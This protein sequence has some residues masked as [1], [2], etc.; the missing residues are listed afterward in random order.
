MSIIHGKNLVVKRKQGTSYTAIAAAKSCDIIV[1]CDTIET[2][3]AT[4]ADW[5]AFIAGRKE[6]EVTCSFLVSEIELDETLVG[7]TVM[8]RFGTSNDYMTGYAI[9]T[10]WHVTGTY[11]NLAQGSFRFKG[12]DGL[13]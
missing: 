11:G 10:E 8:L 12:T 2:A 5:K 9:V 3:P 13:T 4:S 1:R 7:T 6:W